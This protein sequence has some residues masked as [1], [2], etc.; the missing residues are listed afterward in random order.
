MSTLAPVCVPT[1][2]SSKLKL[3]VIKDWV[4]QNILFEIERLELETGEA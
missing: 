2:R 1:N 4:Y 3:N